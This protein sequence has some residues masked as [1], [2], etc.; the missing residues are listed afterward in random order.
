MQY[1]PE[2]SVPEYDFSQ[3]PKERGYS[4]YHGEVSR[5]YDKKREDSDKWKVEQRVIENILSELNSGTSVL[6]IPGGTGRFI[7]AYEQFNLNALLV[8]LSVDQLKEAHKKITHPEKI[9]LIEGDVTNL[10]FLKDNS[11]D[12]SLMCRLTRW[13]SVNPEDDGPQFKQAFKELQRVTRNKI[14]FTARVRGS[15]YARSYELIE[16]VLDGWEISRDRPGYV[17]DYR[18]IELQPKKENKTKPMKRKDVILNLVNENGWTSGIEIGVLDGNLITH[19]LKNNDSL[20]MTGVDCWE[21]ENEIYGAASSEWLKKQDIKA[22]SFSEFGSIV[23][24]NLNSQFG[25]RVNILHGRSTEMADEIE[26]HTFDFV[27]IDA[28]HDYQS[29]LDDI[30]AW[31]PKVKPGGMVIGHDI[32]HK[33]VQL[34]VEEIYKD[35]YEI[36][37]DDVWLVRL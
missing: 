13:L 10:H 15:K 27:F 14:I 18:I 7:P 16:S 11:F 1:I 5:D 34:A 26:K 2:G 12:V 25:S 23:M 37:K 3:Q 32:D 36:L 20:E 31:A 24:D 28:A 22:N 6:D 19:L 8:D 30:Q 33:G 4:K 17:M 9:K 35:N 21:D 29:V